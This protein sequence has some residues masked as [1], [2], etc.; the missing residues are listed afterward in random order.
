[1]SFVFVVPAFMVFIL[2]LAVPFF[3]R[4]DYGFLIRLVLFLSAILVVLLPIGY[5]ASKA[6]DGPE[7]FL[8]WFAALLAPFEWLSGSEGAEGGARLIS[9]GEGLL[10]KIVSNG[11]AVAVTVVILAACA[12]KVL[13]LMAKRRP[14]E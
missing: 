4:R 1:M 5:A 13:H 11:P 9:E 6:S 8:Y 12:L 14:S 2:V 3:G 10:G 7:F